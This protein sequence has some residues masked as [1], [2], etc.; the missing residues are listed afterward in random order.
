MEI[1]TILFDLDGTLLPMDQ[2]R[3]MKYYLKAL[4]GHFRQYMPPEVFQK[5]LWKGTHEML[6]NRGGSETNE[7][8]F[9][10]AFFEA[11][12]E[13]RS[14]MIQTFE[15]FYETDFEQAKEATGTDSQM[16][17]AVHVLQNKGYR[18]AVAT[19]PLFPLQAVEKRI[20]W[21]GLSPDQFEFIT[22][23]ETMHA[24]KPHVAFYQEVLDILQTEP[25]STIMVGNDAHEDLSA[26]KL[27]MQ[28][29]LVTNCLLQ[30]DKQ[31]MTPD[32]HGTTEDFLDFVGTLPSLR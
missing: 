8:T 19:N 26:G 21:A 16:I 25:A 14:E 3:F 20:G 18:M 4:T 9:Y 12:K 6:N 15:Q 30:A 31:A 11:Y 23:F 27:G 29:Y 13:K 22:S 24:C 1:R 10:R 17:K 7:A 2:E 5:L 28:T 32:Y